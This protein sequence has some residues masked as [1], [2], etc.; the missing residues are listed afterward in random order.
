MVG[1]TKS[2]YFFRIFNQI[3]HVSKMQYTKCFA[4]NS[5]ACYGLEFFAM[6]GHWRI[7]D[8]KITQTRNGGKF[9]TNSKTF[10]LKYIFKSMFILS[11]SKHSSWICMNS[12][13]PS[14]LSKAHRPIDSLRLS[15][16]K[17]W[18]DRKQLLRDLDAVNSV[19]RLIIN[20]RT[21]EKAI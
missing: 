20:T 8:V 4:H 12:E 21:R 13:S 3:C 11:P 15:D 18:Y 7:F 10:I 6:A 5:K 19:H 14:M 2:I 1:M 17:F 9:W 16:M